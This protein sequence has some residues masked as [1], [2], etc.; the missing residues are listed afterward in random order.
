MMKFT[1]SKKLSDNATL[2]IVLIWMLGAL[3]TAMAL[4]LAA[5]AID[6]GTTPQQWQNTVLGNEAEF[7]DPLT[8]EE[9]LLRVHTDLFSLILVYILIASLMMRASYSTTVKMVFL[10]LSLGTLIL[11]PM[12]FLGASWLGS[13]AVF[14]AGASFSVFHALMMGS[15]G[16][17][18]ISLLR[19]KI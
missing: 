4:S 12:M 8:L 10:T 7:T 17:I 13:T 2:R 6:Y 14:I 11:Y 19:S 1:V 15:A 9:R 3:M 5:K 16:L 18:L